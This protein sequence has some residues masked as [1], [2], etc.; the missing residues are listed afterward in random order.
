VNMNPQLETQAIEVILRLEGNREPKDRSQLLACWDSICL[1]RG[2]DGL[3]EIGIAQLPSRVDISPLIDHTLLRANAW[4]AEIDQL[5]DEA[6]LYEFA[7][8]CVNPIWVARC[9]RRLENTPVRVSTV[10]GFPLGA[11]T[12]FTKAQEAREA[13]ANGAHEVDM[14]MSIGHAKAGDWEIVRREFREVREAIPNTVLKVILER[15]LLTDHEKVAASRL[16]VE[17]G[18]DFV[19][20]S[21]GFSNGGAT[22]ENVRLIRETVE[23]HCGVKASGGIRCYEEALGMVLAGATRLGISNSMAV[24]KGI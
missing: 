21:S 17:E 20:T 23:N 8:V 6:K 19:K 1:V 10:V 4:T 16:A 11:S 7:S 24:V 5:C 13:V 15:C 12:S 2:G 14:V 22:V 9:L 3:K 18:M